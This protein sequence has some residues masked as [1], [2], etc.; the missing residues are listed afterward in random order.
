MMN[1]KILRSP[2]IADTGRNTVEDQTSSNVER[3]AFEAAAPEKAGSATTN[4]TS[5]V[6]LTKVKP[7]GDTLNDGMMQTMFTLPV[8]YGEEAN[9]A[10][11]QLVKKMGWEEPNVT[12]SHDMGN[13][14]TYF[15]VYGKCQHTVDYTK[16]KVVKV[17][18]DVMDRIECGDY[19]GE[20]IGRDV[21]VVGASTG[22]DAHTVGID[23][24]INMKGFHGH[25]G[26][27][28]F[29]LG[30]QVPNEELIAKAKEVN[31]DA[32]LVSQTV[33]QKDIHI[34][35]LTNMVELVEAEG[36]RDKVL[37]LCGGPRISHEL[38]QELGYDAGFGPH[39]YAEHVMSYIATEIV[40]RGWQ[41]RPPL[42]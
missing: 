38:A 35:N 5:T 31:A 9:E 37:L 4:A 40:N 23:A 19:I 36:I 16:I 17:E 27:E 2:R 33:T 21:V 3:G 22:S 34:M 15:V 29:N 32:I 20:N 13:G 6:D 18:V 8:P 42:K 30:S 25:F 26:L 7:Y 11:R 10:A 39:T 12:Y 14:F 1:N 41:N 28:R 24:I